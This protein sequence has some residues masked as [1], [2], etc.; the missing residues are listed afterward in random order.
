[1]QK[2]FSGAHSSNQ[3]VLTTPVANRLQFMDLVQS[4]NSNQAPVTLRAYFD[5]SM[6]QA[7]TSVAQAFLEAQMTR[8]G[9]SVIQDVTHARDTCWT[10]I[11]LTFK[12]RAEFQPADVLQK[13]VAF[14]DSQRQEAIKAERAALIARGNEQ[15]MSFETIL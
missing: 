10:Q 9:A 6:T 5:K 7:E 11:S 4:P 15:K 3:P 14:I 2:D 12:T 1:M 8:M 13:M